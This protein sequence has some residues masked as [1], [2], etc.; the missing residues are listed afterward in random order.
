MEVEIVI[1]PLVFT[2][3][4]LTIDLAIAQS[5]YPSFRPRDAARSSGQN[6]PHLDHG[7]PRFWNHQRGPEIS[8]SLYD[9]RR[10]RRLYK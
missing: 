1:H 6:Q 8:I 3:N 4:S 5:R 2:R 7:V 9:M 10:S